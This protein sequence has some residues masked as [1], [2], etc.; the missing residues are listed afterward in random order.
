M[1]MKVR[2]FHDSFKMGE[3]DDEHKHGYYDEHDD[4]TK[5]SNRDYFLQ[6]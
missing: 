6:C 4:D 5:F 1:K 3:E 2:K